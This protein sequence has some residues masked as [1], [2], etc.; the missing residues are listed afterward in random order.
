MSKRID[1]SEKCKREIFNEK[2]NAEKS[3]WLC[4]ISTEKGFMKQ[5]YSVAVL[6]LPGQRGRHRHRQACGSSHFQEIQS[7]QFGE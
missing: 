6:A 3:F 2:M 1:A 5:L 7:E 4:E